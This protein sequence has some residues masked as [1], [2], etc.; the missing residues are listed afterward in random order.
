MDLD[1]IIL[2][3]TFGRS[4][5]NKGMRSKAYLC[6]QLKVTQLPSA[7]TLHVRAVYPC[8]FLKINK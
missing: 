2:F 1:S 8:L 6:Y 7:Q 4:G 3:G 5:D